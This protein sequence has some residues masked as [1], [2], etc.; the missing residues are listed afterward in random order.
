MSMVTLPGNA[1][2]SCPDFRNASAALR[3]RGVA[4]APML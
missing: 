3:V 1:D 4:P 2:I